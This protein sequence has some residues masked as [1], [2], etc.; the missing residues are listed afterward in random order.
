MLL[1]SYVFFF[2]RSIVISHHFQSKLSW[3][4]KLVA[5]EVFPATELFPG[6]VVQ[7]CD[8]KG[9]K[10]FLPA[11]GHPTHF[12]LSLFSYIPPLPVLPCCLCP[13]WFAFNW[14]SLALIFPSHLLWSSFASKPHE[15][16][17]PHWQRCY[18]SWAIKELLRPA[19]SHTIMLQMPAQMPAKSRTPFHLSLLKK[20][21]CGG[22]FMNTIL[23]QSEF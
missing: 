22:L 21:L 2:L 6:H 3:C 4:R 17:G 11:S 10:L 16:W 20:T 8:Q 14:L 18:C 1:K 15:S 12:F 9:T 23:R 13:L 19:L 7:F 5:R